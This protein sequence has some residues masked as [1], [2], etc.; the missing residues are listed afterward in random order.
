MSSSPIFIVGCPRSGTKLIRD[1]LRSH[2]NITFPDESHFIPKLYKAYGNPQSEREAC[3]LAA[4][5]LKLHWVK[6]WGLSLEPSSFAHYRYYR[7]VVSRIFEEWARKENKPRWGD[8]TPQYLTEIPTLIELFP[9]CKIIHIYRDGR[10]VS[11][12]WV[13][14]EF[15]PGNIF[16]AAMYWENLVSTGRRMGAMIPPETYLEIRYETLLNQPS[17]VMKCACEFLDEPFTEE[18]LKL[19]TL[20]DSI[21]R[22]ALGNRRL[23]RHDSRTEIDRSNYGKWKKAMLFYDQIIFE[24]VAGDLL[25]TLGYETRG[26]GRR[27]SPS[28]KCLWKSHNF[29]RVLIK[30]L[31]SDGKKRW[32]P[33]SLLMLWASICYHLKS[34]KLI[35]IFPGS[36][37]GD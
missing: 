8:K 37:S 16:T 19:N 15:G 31:N 13:R 11:L 26:V 25:R 22:T 5:I 7:Q 36:N 21:D 29:L 1:L 17:E 9:S 33:S 14:T 24:S 30:R 28:E 23:T 20:R 12:S 4:T 10:D 3:K 35:N 27:I 32:L 2:P 18:V 6:S 34:S